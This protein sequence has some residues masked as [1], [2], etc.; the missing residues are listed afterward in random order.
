MSNDQLHPVQTP[1]A[2]T[3]TDRRL[4]LLSDK[5]NVLVACR[6]IEAQESVT[7]EGQAV[8]M[9]TTLLLGHKVARR[10]IEPGE[11]IMKYGAPIGSAT[12]QITAGEPVHVHNM[13]SDYTRTH[14]IDKSAVRV[15]R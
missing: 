1:G 4:L 15:A 11:K 2:E 9:S 5:D 3:G 7:I 6:Q 12:Q 8:L 10:G 14:T 13:K